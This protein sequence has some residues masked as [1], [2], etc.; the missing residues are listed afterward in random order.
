MGKKA[1][2]LGH[3][4]EETQSE[5]VW[6]GQPHSNNNRIYPHSRSNINNNNMEFQ[7]QSKIYKL[8]NE[9]CGF[10]HIDNAGIKTKLL[11]LVT[12]LI[13]YFRYIPQQPQY[14]YPP[15]PAYDSSGAGVRIREL[16]PDY[17]QQQ[18]IYI[19]AIMSCREVG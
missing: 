10:I 8:E 7:E 4:R 2:L 9:N 11:I 18:V 1:V 3:R 13:V 14:S 6:I 19:F 17:F 15:Q 12:I 5:P 16:Q